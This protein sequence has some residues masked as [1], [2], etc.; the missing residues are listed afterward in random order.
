MP[1]L[2]YGDKSASVAPGSRFFC[3]KVTD[4]P[5]RH[6]IYQ[7]TQSPDG[8]R[9]VSKQ[10][11]RRT[12]LCHASTLAETAAAGFLSL[13]SCSAAAVTTARLMRTTTTAAAATAVITAADAAAK[14]FRKLHSLNTESRC[15]K[16]RRHGLLKSIF[17]SINAFCA[18][19]QKELP[20]IKPRVFAP[21]IRGKP[22]YNAIFLHKTS[23]RTNLSLN[24][25]RK[26]PRACF[27]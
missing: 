14:L 10:N 12:L 1:K 6:N 5:K 23:V 8:G 16:G 24:N 27:K 7:E 21:T 2:L 25:I 11:T 20:S 18:V 26:F 13:S 3:K 19:A 17:G 9:R 22:L 4:F 15:P